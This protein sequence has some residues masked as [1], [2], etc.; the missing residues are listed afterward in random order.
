M[1]QQMN[2]FVTCANNRDFDSLQYICLPLQSPVSL[3]FSSFSPVS[4]LANL[5]KAFWSVR[6]IKLPGPG[7]SLPFATNATMTL[8]SLRALATN[9]AKCSATVIVLDKSLNGP[10]FADVAT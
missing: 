2:Y 5:A 3:F 1:T 9:L 10:V 8:S 4:G 7:F 6:S